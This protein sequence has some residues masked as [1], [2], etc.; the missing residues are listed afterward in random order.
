MFQTN[1][2]LLEKQDYLT[3]ERNVILKVQCVIQDPVCCMDWYISVY[4]CI[5]HIKE[6]TAFRS[7]LMNARSDEFEN[8]IKGSL[9]R[10]ICDSTEL[11]NETR[12]KHRNCHVSVSFSRFRMQDSFGFWIELTW[13]H[14]SGNIPFTLYGLNVYNSEDKA[15]RWSTI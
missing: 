15:L 1:N 3:Q 9:S 7:T 13:R 11:F 2:G 8:F 12:N 4:A 5:T 14:L 6:S 10:S